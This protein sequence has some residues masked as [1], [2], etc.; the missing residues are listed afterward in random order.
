MTDLIE[1]ARRIHADLP[2]VDG[3]ND[4]DSIVWFRGANVVHMGDNFFAGTLP[5]ID[6]DSGGSVEGMIAAA[7]YVLAEADEATRIIPGH[8]PLASVVQLREFR[9]LLM[10]SRNRIQGHIDAGLSL[11]EV[12]AQA[13]IAEFEDLA[14]GFMP[15]ER[16]V[17]I[18]YTALSR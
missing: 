7:D 4:G 8:G 3:H 9:Q 2:V 11:E 18:F 10:T 16:F 5:Y 6:L 15:V 1:R 17:T 13:P 12:L 14:S